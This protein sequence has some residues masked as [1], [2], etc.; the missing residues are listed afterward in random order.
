MVEIPLEYQ[1]CHASFSNGLG[2]NDSR[3]RLEL[4]T[5]GLEYSQAS[6]HLIFSHLCLP[7]LQG[8]AQRSSP[9]F[10]AAGINFVEDNF[11]MVGDG[12]G[13]RMVQAH[14]IYYA[15]VDLTGGGAQAV[16]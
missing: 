3:C 5:W 14:Y 1:L 16:M 12:D 4:L 9:P 10:L 15:A 6:G 13:F 7:T 8:R 2:A 11:S